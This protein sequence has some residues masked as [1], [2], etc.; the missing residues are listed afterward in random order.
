M[1]TTLGVEVL[2]AGAGCWMLMRGESSTTR[3]CCD[4]IT[5]AKIS[6]IATIS[7]K[8]PRKPHEEVVSSVVVTV[9]TR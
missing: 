8:I 1:G 2:G 3:G 5:A 4:Q 6:P 9:S 7:A